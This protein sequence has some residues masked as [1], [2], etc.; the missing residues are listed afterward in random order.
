MASDAVRELTDT[1]F[2]TEVIQADLPVLVD[3][4]AEW[5]QPCRMLAPTIDEIANEYQGKAKVGKLDTDANRETSMKYNIS[6]IPTVILFK[7]GEVQKKFVGLT[8]KDQFKTALDDVVSD[9]D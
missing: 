6:A 3:F 1:N 2:D 7:G 4:W 9:S 5:C 8:S